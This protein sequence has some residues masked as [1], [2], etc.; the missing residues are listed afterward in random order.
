[1]VLDQWPVCIQP[2]VT[3]IADEAYRSTV[4]NHIMSKGWDLMEDVPG[5]PGW[6]STKAHSMISFP[7]VFGPHPALALTYLSSYEGVGSAVVSLEGG[8]GEYVVNAKWK[9]K[10]SW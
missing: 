8:K 1:M 5:K 4:A 9:D 10:T 6:I 2:L 3:Y 7:L